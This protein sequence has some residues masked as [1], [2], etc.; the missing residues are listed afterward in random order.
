[1]MSAVALTGCQEA[2]NS[3]NNS[4]EDTRTFDAGQSGVVD[5]VSNAN[6]VDIVVSAETHTI[7]RDAVVAAGLVDVLSNNGPFTVFAPNNDA[8]AKLPEGTLEN[9]LL[10]ENLTTLKTIVTHHAVPGTYDVEALKKHSQMFMATGYYLPVTVDGDD[11]F[12]DGNKVLGTIETTNGIIHV[13]DQVLL[14]PSE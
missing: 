8:F 14:P 1:M 11:V 7:L 12:I 9:L 6:I 13:I 10:P 4:S 5:D 2:D 3:A